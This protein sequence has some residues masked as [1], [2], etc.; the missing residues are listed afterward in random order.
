[1]E[2]S[3]LPRGVVGTLGS[4][5]PTGG[6]DDASLS[7]DDEDRAAA[8]PGIVEPM[9]TAPKAPP[10]KRTNTVTRS[11]S[12]VAAKAKAV[13]PPAGPPAVTAGFRRLLDVL[14]LVGTAVAA[15]D[16]FRPRDA[17]AAAARNAHVSAAA[18]A[19]VAA[20]TAADSAFGLAKRP[21]SRGGGRVGREEH[22]G[23]GVAALNELVVDLEKVTR[24]AAWLR[25]RVFFLFC[26]VIVSEAHVR[27]MEGAASCLQKVTN[28]DG[29]ANSLMCVFVFY[30]YLAR[31]RDRRWTSKLRA[32]ELCK[33]A[34]F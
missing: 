16:V 3:A 29:R 13:P 24:A 19:A 17:T 6:V 7:E 18:A 31:A 9:L 15:E 4:S 28:Q 23:A 26:F 30:C 2:L 5:G 10:I 21:A 12:A 34:A 27:G 32:S 8:A 22:K 25:V 14:T 33:R 20:A 11:K 1:M